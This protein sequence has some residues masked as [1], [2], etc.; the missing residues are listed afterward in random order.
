MVVHGIFLAMIKKLGTVLVILLLSTTTAWSQPARRIL[1]LAP[2]I[3]ELLFAVGAGEWIVGTVQFSNY[4]PEAQ[5]IPRIGSYEQFDMEA[6]VDLAPDLIVAWPG[7]NPQPQ[8]EKLEQL[9]F[10]LFPSN[11]QR[12]IDIPL[13]MRRLGE[14]VGTTAIASAQ[15]TKFEQAYQQLRQR[16]ANKTKVRVFYQIWNHPLMTVNGQHL[17]DDIIR[18]CG[19]ENIFSALAVLA[20]TVSIEAV[21]QANPHTI[22]ASGMTEERPEWLDDWRQW[23]QL[24]AVSQNNLFVIPPDLIQRHTPRIMMGAIQ[25]CEHLEAVRNG[26]VHSPLPHPPP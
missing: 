24:T 12:M 4:P 21:L 20:P 7:G 10:T 25:M 8:L 1:S 26:T 13:D 18:L 11:P 3:T 17:I 9:G 14:R 2:H 6:I 19:G 5:K 22:I 15:A 16:F 23:P